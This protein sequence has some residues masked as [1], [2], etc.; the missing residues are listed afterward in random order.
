LIHNNLLHGKAPEEFRVREAVMELTEYM[1]QL[2]DLQEIFDKTYPA[3]PREGTIGY[4]TNEVFAV[5]H[6]Q[7]WDIKLSTIDEHCKV[8]SEVSFHVMEEPKQNVHLLLD[9]CSVVLRM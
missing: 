5:A 6:M 3:G 1:L 7:Q 8:T 2:E 4:G 9:E